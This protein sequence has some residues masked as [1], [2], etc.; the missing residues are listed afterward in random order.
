[1]IEADEQA[2]EVVVAGLLDLAAIELDVV[3]DQPVGGYQAFE[4]VAERG[5]VGGQVG[6]MFLERHE[7]TGLTVGLCAADQ[8][9]HGEQ[10]LAAA[11]RPAQQGGTAGGNAAAG[12]L[13]ETGDAAPRLG[14]LSQDHR[15]LASFGAGRPAARAHPGKRRAGLSATM[16]PASVR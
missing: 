3:D 12:D 7:D 4:V 8:E 16:S 6:R 1:M 2:F 10:G 9:G 5:D 14:Q 15:H 11:R 13:V